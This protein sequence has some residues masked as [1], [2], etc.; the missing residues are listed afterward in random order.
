[1]STERYTPGHN[2]HAVRFMAGR[3]AESHAK[4]LRRELRPGLSLLDCGC[5]PGVITVG[6]AKMVSPGEVHAVDIFDEQFGH[7]REQAEAEGLAVTFHQA[8]AYE[9]PFEAAYFDVVFANAL[10]EHL[11]DPVAGLRE[12]ARVL[13]PGG[14]VGVCSPDW[15]GFIV[16]PPSDELAEALESYTALKRQNGGDPLAGRS[17]G[18][19]VLE[20]GFNTP[21]VDARYER[22]EDPDR[23]AEFLALQLDDVHPQSARTLRQWA[24]QPGAMFAQA[25]VSVVAHR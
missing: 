22:Y 15:G 8:S 25:W 6:L 18:S 2:A 21:R 14:T 16:T 12:M 19:W 23:I 10:L 4:F 9:L 3:S 20:A 5:G 1:V 7:A 11:A 24:K 17:L 13:R